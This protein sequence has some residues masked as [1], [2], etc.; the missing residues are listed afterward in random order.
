MVKAAVLKIVLLSALVAVAYASA[1][2]SFDAAAL[3]SRV[4]KPKADPGVTDVAVSG[5]VVLTDAELVQTHA[6]PLFSQSRRPFVPKPQVVEQPVVQVEEAVVAPP[7]S[8]P[9]RLSLLGTNVGGSTPSA[10]VRNKESEEVRWLKIGEAFDGWILSSAS[11][12]QAAFICR[13]RQGGDCDY[14]LTLYSDSGGE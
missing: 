10:L 14:R 9:R 3:D 7:V 12:D 13:E 2:V 11:A 4:S 6:R 8:L 5:K 1:W